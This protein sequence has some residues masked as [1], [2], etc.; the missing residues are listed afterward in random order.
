MER[1][2]SNSSVHLQLLLKVSAE[3]GQAD[4]AITNNLLKLDYWAHHKSHPRKEWRQDDMLAD[5]LTVIEQLLLNDP[6]IMG[7]SFASYSLTGRTIR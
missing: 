2:P 6:S 3:H 5:K 7:G 1:K 4:L